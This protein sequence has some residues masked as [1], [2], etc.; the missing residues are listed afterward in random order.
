M[1]NLPLEY[2]PPVFMQNNIVSSCIPLIFIFIELSKQLED[3]SIED[4][5]QL[6]SDTGA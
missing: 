5:G 2:I 1:I 6:Q 3:T 4:S